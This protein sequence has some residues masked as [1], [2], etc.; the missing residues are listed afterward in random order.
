MFHEQTHSVG[1]RQVLDMN[2][3]GTSHA[4]A[5]QAFRAP[6]PCHDQSS[7]SSWYSFMSLHHG[8]LHLCPAHLMYRRA[9]VM[10]MLLNPEVYLRKCFHRPSKLLMESDRCWKQSCALI[11]CLVVQVSPRNLAGRYETSLQHTFG[12]ASPQYYD[13]TTKCS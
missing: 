9:A 4:A 7:Q 1:L 5:V 10:H 11:G 8:V 13:G 2:E 6:W 3:P 12:S